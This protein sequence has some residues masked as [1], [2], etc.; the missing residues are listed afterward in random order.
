[1]A[2]TDLMEALRA[3]VSQGPPWN[4][5]DLSEWANEFLFA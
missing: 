4:E 1:M 5:D 3:I 2:H